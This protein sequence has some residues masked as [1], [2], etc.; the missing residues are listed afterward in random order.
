MCLPGRGI[1]LIAL[2]ITIIVLLILAGITINLTVGQ[3]GILNRAQ[4]AGKNYKESEVRE[5]V[6]LALLDLQTEVIFDNQDL[7]VEY[8]LNKL[9]E[10]GVF[11]EIDI[12][13]QTGIT[14]GY[15]ITL[16]YDENGNVIIVDMVPD[17]V[18]RIQA[19]VITKGYTKGPVEISVSVKTKG[20][21][22]TSLNIPEGMT[23]KEEGIYEVVSNGT[24]V[25]QAVLGNGETIERE[26]EITTI[27]N[28]APKE[29]TIVATQV[30]KKL[31]IT[32]STED[33]E[34][35]ETSACSGIDKYEYFVK[36]PSEVEYSKIPY[37]TN[38][39]EITEYGNYIMKV[40]AYDK[41]G[42][43]K[44]SSEITVKVNVKFDK[45]SAG[46]NNHML[47]IDEEGN[48]WAWGGNSYGQLGDGT[49]VDR[50]N[51][52]QI[53]TERKFKEVS[54]GSL[55]SLAI[56]EEGKL[57]SWGRNEKGQLGNNTI[58]N[59]NNLIRVQME[60]S[61]SFKMIATGKVN[62]MAIDENGNLWAWGD[63]SYGQL[64]DGTKTLKKVPVKIKEETKFKK[65]V[66][67]IEVQEVQ[68]LA[69]DEENNLWGWGNNAWGQVGDGTKTM[70][71]SPTI[72][73]SGT[74]FNEVA[75]GFWGSM[76]QTTEGELW[77]WGY[78]GNNGQ[79]ADATDEIRPNPWKNPTWKALNFFTMCNR[80]GLGIDEE[81]MLWSWGANNA[82]QVGDGTKTNRKGQVQI[83]SDVK[84]KVISTGV[85]SSAAIDIEGNIWIWG[86][87]LNKDI[88]IPTKIF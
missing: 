74:K 79:L 20:E 53:S 43:G 12:E 67:P 9:E 17:G 14:G 39:I 7:T 27:D 54:A 65:V 76:A 13:E 88:L 11:E 64:G 59:S 87:L 3:N 50:E 5:N 85:Y 52:I 42:N 32:A 19:K 48:L 21:T 70:R 15:V 63:N 80:H 31:I 23:K 71:T 22:V 33:M 29:F 44:E 41:V 83:K 69:I 86:H 24:Y 26:L 38:E 66:L 47:A 78:S 81:G 35:T 25:I 30:N 73:K 68:C 77:S 4:E 62:S 75:A 16:G 8:A 40:I 46:G 34:A 28:L 10:K 45:V 60:E 36:K 1:T 37:T 18:A 6:E 55:H 58:T 51:P 49:N 61:L 84:F 2:V 72:I 57:W 82:G 56:D